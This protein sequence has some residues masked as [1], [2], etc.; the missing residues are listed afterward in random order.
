M[1]NLLVFVPVAASH[2]VADPA[3]LWRSSLAF[4]AFCLVASA[5]Y[6]FNDLVDR[7]R[8]RNHPDKC[9]RPIAAGTLSVSDA[10]YAVAALAATGFLVALPLGLEFLSWIAAY[11]FLVVLYS[12][13]V[14]K[15]FVVDTWVLAAFYVLRIVAGGSAS[16]ITPSTWLL[17]FA[18]FLFF[19]L[20]VLKRYR[21]MR[22][23]RTAGRTGS[24][25]PAAYASAPPGSM[26]AAGWASLAAAL[27]VLV[28]YLCS[29]AVRALYPTPALLWCLPLLIIAWQAHMWRSATLGR[30]DSDPVLFAIRDRISLLAVAV[31]GGVVWSAASLG[32]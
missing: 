7:E 17:S 16:G 30:L 23:S 22:A 13:W 8:D 19:S 15:I 5:M 14:K 31:M 29:D 1:K 32:A 28:A 6:L 26:I 21:D 24:V 20:A 4:L 3:L 2:Q 27:A 25:E 18:L 9:Q 12:L 10:G 11:A